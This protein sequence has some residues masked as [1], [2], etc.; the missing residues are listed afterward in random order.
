MKKNLLLFT[1]LFVFI[2]QIVKGLLGL[3]MN[4]GESISVIGNFFNLTL[5]YNSGAA[6]GLFMGG[7]WFFVLAAM[8]TLN[9]VYFLIKDKK[10]SKLEI[11]A[12]SML[13][14]GIIGN[15]VD[16]VVYGAVIDFL[17]FRFFGY[18]FAIFN[19]ADAF[20]VISVIIL[21]G[22]IVKEEIHGKNN[23]RKK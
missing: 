4:F 21:V 3:F 16:R 11:F 13:S 17:D 15:M 8:I 1:I 7:R 22:L 20:I 10:L 23:R 6:F 2:D 12:Y 18:N 5:V 19:F 14:G 9:I